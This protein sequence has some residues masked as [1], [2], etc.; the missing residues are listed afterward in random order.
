MKKLIIDTDPGHDDMLA[1]LLLLKSNQFDIRAITTVA[2]NA[3]IE[4]VTR[5]AQSI[6]GLVKSP[7]PVYSGKPEPLARSLVK[8][9]VHGEGGLS[10]LDTSKTKFRLTDNAPEKIVETIRKFPGQITILALGPL[11][12][13]ARA[14]QIDPELPSL[15]TEIVMMGGAIDVPGNKNRVAEFNFFVDPEAADIVFGAKVP[16]TMVPLDLCNQIVIDLADFEAL[17]GRLGDVLR[18]MMRDFSKALAVDEGTGGI[19]AYDALAAYVLLNRDSF[20]FRDMNVQIET[21]GEH[22]AGMSVAER[23]SYKLT[24]PNVRVACSVDRA[25]FCSDLFAA[26]ASQ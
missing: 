5:N 4:D 16:K 1:L 25:A 24:E 10:G 3:A 14:F 6:L 21:K 11:S 13:L 23:R 12:N 26:L 19:L 9:V 22:T 18:P 20:E 8:A 15:I 17:K 2:G 7:L